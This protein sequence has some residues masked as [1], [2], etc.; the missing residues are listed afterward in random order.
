MRR[1]EKSIRNEHA[2]GV[3]VN[4]EQHERDPKVKAIEVISHIKSCRPV[5]AENTQGSS[6]DQIW[7]FHQKHGNC[8]GGGG[9][10]FGRIVTFEELAH[11]Q[12]LG[13]GSTNE[14]DTCRRY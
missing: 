4:N 3:A 1:V 2:K 7:D 13:H 11:E 5:A 14:H 10:I 6:D 12:E 9:I 8:E